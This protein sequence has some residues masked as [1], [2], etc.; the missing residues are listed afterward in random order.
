MKRSSFATVLMVLVC[1][2]LCSISTYAATIQLPATGQTKCWDTTGTEIACAGTGQDGEIQAGKAWPDPRFADNGNGTVTD[3]LTGL[4]WSKDANPANVTKSWQEALDYVKA[5]NIQNYMGYNDWR[6]PNIN[7]LISVIYYQGGDFPIWYNAQKISNIALSYYWSSTTCAANNETISAWNISLSG[8]IYCFGKQNPSYYV[9]P[10]RGVSSKVIAKTG[11]TSCWSAEGA[12]LA[13]CFGTGQDGELQT[14]VSLPQQRFVDNSILESDNKTITDNLTTL[15]WSKDTN[16]AGIAMPWQ[17]ALNYVSTLNAINYQGYSDWRLPNVLELSSIVDRRQNLLVSWLASQGFENLSTTIY[18]TSTSTAYSTSAKYVHFINGHSYYA[19]S[20]KSKNYFVWP[21]RGGR[22]GKLGDLSI[23]PTTTSFPSLYPSDTASKVFTVGNTLLTNAT[24]TSLSITG[25]NAADFSLSDGCSGTTLISKTSCNITVNFTPHSCGI[26]NATLNVGTDQGNLTAALSGSSCGVGPAA[27]GGVVRDATTKLPISGASIT[28]GGSGPYTTDMGGKYLAEN[29]TSGTLSLV[30]IKSG[31]EIKRE[32]ITLFPDKSSLHDIYLQPSSSGLRVTSVTSKYSNGKPYYFLPK[33]YI[34]SQTVNVTFT[35][36]VDWNGKTPDYVKFITPRATY[37]EY[38][39]GLT[40]PVSRTFNMSTEFDPCTTLKVVAVD[41]NSNESSVATADFMVAKNI[42]DPLPL[43]Q[44][45]DDGGSFSYR[46]NSS[47]GDDDSKKQLNFYN[48]SLDLANFSES[49]FKDQKF[50]FKLMPTVSFEYDSIDQAKY[51]IDWGDKNKGNIFNEKYKEHGKLETFKK[52][53][54]KYVKDNKLDGKLPSIGFDSVSLTFFPY[55]DIKAEFN[56]A[57]CQNNDQGWKYGGEIGVAIDGQINKAV[58]GVIF[59]PPPVIVPVPWYGKM[60]LEGKGEASFAATGPDITGGDLSGKLTLQPKLSFTLGVGIDE[61][62]G[63]EITASGG[64]GVSLPKPLDDSSVNVSAEI[65]A[66]LYVTLYRYDVVILSGSKCLL[67]S[68]NDP[69]F[70][71]SA[72]TLL[73]GSGPG[74]FKPIPRDYLKSVVP[75]D[76]KAAPSYTVKQVSTATQEYSVA[77]APVITSTFPVSSASLSSNGSNVNLLW[78]KDNTARTLMNR[79]M[80]QHASFDGAT[81]STP[82]AVA[83]NGTADFNP[84]SLTF[85]DGSMVAVWEDLKTTLPDTAQLEDMTPLMEIAAAVYDPTTKTWGTAVRLTNNG[86][87]DR[88]PKL[89]GKDKNN[90]LLT[91]ISNSQNDLVGSATK[92]NSLYAAIFNGTVWSTP[93]LLASIPNAIKRYSVVYDGTVANIV[94]ALDTNNDTSTLEDLELY[95]LTNSGGTW[96][97]LTRLT[98]DAVI[99]DN[100]QLALDSSNNVVMTW[101]KGNELS[102]VVNFDFANRTVIRTEDSYS[103]TLADYKQ[104]QATDGKVAVIYA[105]N[106][107]DSTSDLFGLFYDPVFKVW[108]EPKQLTFDAETE[109]WPSIAFLGADTIISVYNRKLLI[110]PDGTPTTGALTDLYMLKHTMGDD[111]ALEAGSLVSDPRNPAPGTTVTLSAV[112][113]NLGDKVAQ[114]IPVTF[115]NGDPANGGTSI[116]TATITGPFKPG[117]VQTVTVPWTTP[118][119]TTPLTVY[120]VIDPNSAI[121][122][123]NRANNVISSPLAQPD[124]SIRNITW[125]KLAATKYSM[126]VTVA[127]IGGT[128]SAASTV[129][130]HNGS[131]TGPVIATLTVPTL[132]RFASVD[133]AYIWDASATI[134]PYYTVVGMVDEANLIAESDELNNSFTAVL[135]GNL[136]DISVLPNPLSGTA[137]IGQTSTAL[138][139]IRNAGTAPLTVSGITKSGTDATAFTVA[140]SGDNACPGM[141]PTIQA[142]LSCTIGVSI[143]PTALVTKTATVTIASNDPDTPSVAVPVSVTGVDSGAPVISAFVMPATVKTKTIPFTTLTATDNVAITGWVVTETSTPPSAGDAGWLATKPTGY[144][145][146]SNGFKV[147]NVWAKDAAGNV[148]APVQASTAVSIPTLTTTINGVGTVSSV[149]AGISCSNATCTALFDD[150]TN[151]TLTASSSSIVTFGGWSGACTNLTGTCA[152][153][154]TADK[155]VTATFNLAPKA[156][157]GSSG[158]GSFADAYAAA[159]NNDVIMLLEDNLTLSTVINKS[160]TL[161]GGYKSDYTRSTSGYTVLEGTLIIGSGSVV[162]DRIIIG[163]PT[164]GPDF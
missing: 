127:N 159:G 100:P 7:E 61:L 118:A 14:G 4:I 158:Y 68:C 98:T 79:T 147:L 31:Y 112:A 11:Q 42:G 91:W 71:L 30:A 128:A 82:V 84:S 2:I 157:I 134:Q 116:G 126:I 23:S 78:L 80:L 140:P 106:S 125:E 52:D 72:E 144:A 156:K 28:V 131:S 59:T 24:V 109:Q 86:N 164:G 41:S 120:A 124:L 136:Q 94:L 53:F 150:A 101:V 89:A 17:D 161:Q 63:G 107:E 47:Y 148:S 138:L 5:L 33:E 145:V 139:T 39:F 21:V 115:Y 149:P 16:P 103:S 65:L 69:L 163:S 20:Y 18:W 110:N 43:Y 45:V 26:Q 143:T 60:K 96:G 75:A 119:G 29:L 56:P 48:L 12:L 1:A 19:N 44:F 85:S 154:M 64:F 70:K 58:Q 66:S 151:V 162:A 27:V 95:R 34:G 137:N 15:I 88:T 105:D 3:N 50:V 22:G 152:L 57:S 111:L 36:D 40:A 153:S 129:T 77:S 130:L 38:T 122:T 99:D 6:L 62:F 83:D 123:L 121:D 74:A 76:F 37:Y 132:Q 35:V 92:P 133:L 97:G 54:F 141:T 102:S 142:G 155:V 93:Q 90:L 114:N 10:V 81:W 8:N 135:D 67:G 104:A 55:V 113:Q 13:S 46:N 51:R 108:G 73:S 87:L 117:A 49:F 32:N 25:S 160:V 146:S 9:W